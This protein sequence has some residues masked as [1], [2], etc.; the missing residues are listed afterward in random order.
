MGTLFLKNVKGLSQ[1]QQIMNIKH[2]SILV[3]VTITLIIN[4]L[5]NLD[6]ITSHFV[7]YNI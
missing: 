7:R 3:K 2:M 1:R 4:H 5:S 6:L